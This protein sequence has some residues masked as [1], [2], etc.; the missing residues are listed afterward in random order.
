LIRP[1]DHEVFFMPRIVIV[2]GGIS[3]L[4]LAY[5]LEQTLPHA[6][7]T[8]LERDTRPGGKIWTEHHDGFTVELGP[9]GFLDT[10]PTTKALSCDLGL[11]KHLTLASEVASKNRFLFLNGKLRLLPANPLAFLRSDIISWRG[12][13]ALLAELFCRSRC[14]LSDESVDAFARRRAGPETAQVLVDAFVTGIYAGDPKLLSVRAAFPRLVALE[15]QNGSVLRGMI[16]SA[17]QRRQEAAARGKASERAGRL[18]S[19]REGLRLLIET[20][21]S[22]LRGSVTLGVTIKR[23]ERNPNAWRVRGEGRD[24]WD[25]DTVVLSCPAYQQA[26]I[27]ADLDRELAEQVGAIPYNRVAVV[28]LGYRRDDIPIPLDGF[29]YL[30]PQCSR[31]DVLGVQWCSST[32]PDRAPEGMVLLRAMCGGWQ[33]PEVVSWDDGRIIQAVAAELRVSLGVVAPPV[34]QRIIR[35][36][37]AIPQYLIGH[38]ERVA[39]IEARAARH[40]GLFLAG[41]AYHGIALNDCTEQAEVLAARV[42]QFLGR[43]MSDECLA[44]GVASAPRVPHLER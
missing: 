11:D 9:N 2:G 24:C 10:K 38:L 29:G 43:G 33:H 30:T 34:F 37:R 19:F 25:A 28:A 40:A 36:D 42:A 13:L 39:A 4:A 12:K 3:G 21:C 15:E 16:A 26:A 8:I 35:W 23:L 14:P 1:A 22:R 32:Y 20:L 7:V 31:G 6:T 5:R 17:K 27:L 41:N 18:W 44:S